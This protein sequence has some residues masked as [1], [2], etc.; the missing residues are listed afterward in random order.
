MCKSKVG[1]L[2]GDSG[3]KKN[4]KKEKSW[5]NVNSVLQVVIM[6]KHH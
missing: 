2:I 1:L 6:R 3:S 5:M 4:C